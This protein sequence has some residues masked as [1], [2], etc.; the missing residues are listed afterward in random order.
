MK[1]RKPIWKISVTT[2]RE[3][4]EA[5]TEIIAGFFNCPASSF[6][7][8]EKETTQAIAF[9]DRKITSEARQKL[10]EAL[11]QIKNFGL[12]VGAAKIS[13][14]KVRPQDWAE[15]W[16]RHFKPIEIGRALLL[17]PSWSKKL[18]RAN[19]AIVT[20]DPGLSFGTGQHPTT[21]YC[22]QE[23]VRNANSLRMK[24]RSRDAY[25]ENGRSFLDLGTGSGILAI[26]AAKLGYK[27]ICAI[28]FDLESVRTACANARANKVKIPI[29]HGDVAKLPAKP[30]KRFDLVCAN[31]IS[32]LLIA[33]RKR[34]VAQVKPDGV[35][36]TAGIL[37]KEFIEV[38]QA[39][40]ELGLKLVRAKS[41]KEW[42][43]GSFCF[44]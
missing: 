28:D 43:S 32:N 36:V 20:L 38:Q 18:P 26:A 3:A 4:E 37:K 9:I 30:K 42:R 34:I 16:K 27:E 7:D 8:F 15:S 41:Q 44:V 21:L 1:T 11:N 5:V 17:K 12:D 35:L 10:R 14:S 31:L 22:L 24:N 40:E 39:F 25:A 29:F 23:I 6:F 2:T 19:Q 33:E 13:I